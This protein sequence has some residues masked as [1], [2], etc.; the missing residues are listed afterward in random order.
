MG[1]GLSKNYTGCIGEGESGQNDGASWLWTGGT[2]ADTVIIFDWDDTLLCTTSVTTFQQCD[3]ERLLQLEHAVEA[4]LT[5]AMGLGETYIVTNGAE[6]WIQQSSHSFLPRLM[7]LLKRLSKVVSARAAYEKVW[8]GEP[9]VWKQAAFEKILSERKSSSR[10]TN[11]VNLLVLGDSLAEI[12]AAQTATRRLRGTSV[13]KTVKFKDMPSIDELLGQLR[14]VTQVLPDLV[15][16]DG[17]ES[18]ALISRQLQP[19]Q[20]YLIS[21]ASGWQVA[22]HATDGAAGR[23]LVQA[24]AQSP[25]ANTLPYPLPAVAQVAQG[26]PQGAPYAMPQSYNPASFDQAGHGLNHGFGH[27]YGN[28]SMTYSAWAR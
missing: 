25:A 15:A 17:N 21:W 10:F 16:R 11:G 8:P 23:R 28:P 2:P 13:I 5:V 6:D 1:E 4:V 26:I 9:T 27:G 22:N 18:K 24:I 7:P 12:D 20:G 3:A 19:Q 14:L